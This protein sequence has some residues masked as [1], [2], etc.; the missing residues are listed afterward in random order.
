MARGCLLASSAR[1]CDRSGPASGSPEGS[2]PPVQFR[3]KL[4]EMDGV[5][6]RES[7]YSKLH[8][9]TRQG[10]CAVWTCGRD[11]SKSLVDMSAR[12]VMSPQLLAQSDA[13]AHFSQRT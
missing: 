4:L 11:V 10:T 7:L 12:V 8:A 6:W 5:T 9:V 1:A 2:P 13:V 3:V